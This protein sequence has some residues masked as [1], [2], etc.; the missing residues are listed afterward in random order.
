MRSHKKKLPFKKKQINV[1]GI[2]KQHLQ[3]QRKQWNKA[4]DKRQAFEVS[5]LMQ[6]KG[7]AVDQDKHLV[8][9]LFAWMQLYLIP[10]IRD[11]LW[12][13]ESPQPVTQPD[14][15]YLLSAR[16]C[17]HLF[18]YPLFY[19]PFCIFSLSAK[20]LPMC[21]SVALWDEG[22]KGERCVD[23][24]RGFRILVKRQ[25]GNSPQRLSLK[26]PLL[27]LTLC[28]GSPDKPTT[29]THTPP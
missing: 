16:H 17:S 24:H 8:C 19:L 10:S 18:T 26:P 2:K 25:P 5:L 21:L 23:G 20:C 15:L 3:L 14:I 6:V 11:P 28:P 22:R 7:V 1:G 13:S 4:A 12:F 9:M 27:H 29:H